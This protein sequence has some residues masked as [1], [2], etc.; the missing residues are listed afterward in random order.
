MDV[1]RALAEAK[2]HFRGGRIEEA[3]RAAHEA[4]A[5]APEDVEA[6]HLLGVLAHAA[7]R[8]DEALERLHRALQLRPDDARL[9]SHL[10]VVLQALGRLEEAEQAFAA[11]VA[12]D[13]GSA[14]AHFNRGAALHA[15]R[16]LPEAIEAYR[17]ALELDPE[18]TDAEVNLGNALQ[19][20]GR[21][22]EAM[23]AY[24]GTLGREPG[25]P[26]ALHNLAAALRA[27]GRTEEAV[28]AAR[29]AVAAAPRFA[30]A[31][32]LCGALLWEAGQRAE[33]V[34]ALVRATDLKPELVD[35]QARLV[36]ALAELGDPRAAQARYNLGAA[37]LRRGEPRP[38]L[39]AFDANIERLEHVTRELALKAIALAELGEETA[40][41]VLLDCERFVRVVELDAPEGYSG[42]E[43]FNAALARHVASH[44]SLERTPAGQ[45]TRLGLQTGQLL[46][47]P[48]G[49][50]AA[51]ERL[52]RREVEAYLGA[53]PR[54][55]GHPFLKAPPERYALSMWGLLL[56]GRGHQAPHI[57]PDAWLSAVYYAALPERM[58]G[59]AGDRAG[60]LEFGVPDPGF[61]RF[62]STR[63]FPVEPRPG[64]LVLFPSYFHHRTVPFEAPGNRI[65]LSFDV[66]P[67]R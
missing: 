30:E 11:A 3:E 35:A 8:H 29:K 25:Q 44:P 56:D 21:L 54:D 36:R 27:A 9:R 59:E 43:A 32:A 1:A 4:L 31:Q 62:V 65:S 41:A 42:I 15:L 51:F 53:Y 61:A 40:L 66:V 64:R 13:P 24:R 46:V 60:W 19:A 37:L 34:E 33:A 48:K 7:G 45:T 58:S 22:E 6:L 47:E 50:I 23:A 16:R 10:G 2:E 17:R 12:A 18:H 20:S 26:I 55:P 14:E 38:A 5:A 67:Q 63:V 39:A 57:H 28:A 49:P 52:V